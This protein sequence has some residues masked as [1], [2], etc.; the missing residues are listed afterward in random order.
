MDMDYY[1]PTWSAQ[2]SIVLDA[3]GLILRADSGEDPGMPQVETSKPRIYDR[4][5]F[6]LALALGI[7]GIG[8]FLMY[9]AAPGKS[10]TPR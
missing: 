3:I 2:P 10:S 1:H 6:V 9:R 8:F 7:L 5:P 4:Y